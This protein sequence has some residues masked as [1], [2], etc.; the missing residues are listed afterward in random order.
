MENGDRA[1]PGRAPGES[2]AGEGPGAPVEKAV[3]AG[4]ETGFVF[5]PPAWFAKGIGRV[6]HSV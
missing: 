5:P 4:A 1:G 6:T 2:S 3:G